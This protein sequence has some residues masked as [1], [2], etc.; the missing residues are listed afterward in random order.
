MRCY[1]WLLLLPLLLSGCGGAGKA[2][3]ALRRGQDSLKSIQRA[4]AVKGWGLNRAATTES[5]EK[6]V[7]QTKLDLLKT[8]VA[9]GQITFEDV[10]ASL[11]SLSKELGVDATYAYEDFAYIMLMQ[12]G[13]ER[14]HQ[15]I[16]IAD[17]YLES[18]KPIWKHLSKSGRETGRDFINEFQQWGPLFQDA[19]KIA[20]DFAGQPSK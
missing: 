12:I 14:A 1:A 11:D 6:H 16:G 10:E 7:L 8:Q 17:S 2:Q 18:K 5:R 15:S 13:A 19:K 4:T 20:R 9:N 3:Q